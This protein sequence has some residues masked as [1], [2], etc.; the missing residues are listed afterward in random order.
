M[1]FQV[2]TPN[3][4]IQRRIQDSHRRDANPPGAPKYDFAKISEK[5]NENDKIFGHTGGAG[6]AR[7]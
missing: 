7:P 2:Q 3:V 5:L 4:N 6:C 1:V